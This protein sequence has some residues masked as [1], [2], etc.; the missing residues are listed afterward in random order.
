M[1]RSA[2][3]DG[4]IEEWVAR[5]MIDPGKLPELTFLDGARLGLPTALSEQLVGHVDVRTHRG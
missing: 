1:S 3:A 5:P 2:R 4:P